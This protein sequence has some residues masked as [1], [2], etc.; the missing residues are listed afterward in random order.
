MNKFGA[1][2]LTSAA[3]MATAPAEAQMNKM[4]MMCMMGNAWCA[5]DTGGN[6]LGVVQQVGILWRQTGATVRF[7]G[8]SAMGLVKDTALF[9]ESSNCTG[10]PYQQSGYI[11][12]DLATVSPD[13]LPAWEQWDGSRFWSTTGPAEINQNIHSNVCYGDV[14]WGNPEG[15]C[16]AYQDITAYGYPAYAPAAVVETP[17]FVTPSVACVAN[18]SCVT[19]K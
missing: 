9:Y 16:M 4:N 18:Q 2:L 11:N 17:H 3:L 15:Q 8:Y 6:M 5:Y 12:E 7:I 1:A 13:G 14:C 10:Q 19:V